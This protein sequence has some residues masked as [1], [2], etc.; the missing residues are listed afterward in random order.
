MAKTIRKSEAAMAATESK[1]DRFIRVITPRISRAVKSIDL[2]CN[3]SGSSYEYTEQLV[4]QIT[5]ALFA[6]V[7]RVVES[8]KVT[9]SDKSAF[10]FKDS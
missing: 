4:E 3:C 6:A 10:A 1:S 8:Y 2:I 7:N 9:K 5:E